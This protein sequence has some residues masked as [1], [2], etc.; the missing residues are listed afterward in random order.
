MWS[1]GQAQLE[2]SFSE[3]T[4]L[5][6]KNQNTDSLLA[7]RIHDHMRFYKH[8]PH[9]IKITTKLQNH[10]KQCNEEETPSSKTNP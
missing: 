7:Q 5:L 3:N 1:H 4:K 8:Q 6:T 9:T 10:V 2:R